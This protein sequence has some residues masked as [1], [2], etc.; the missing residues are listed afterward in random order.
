[1]DIIVFCMDFIRDSS[2]ILG[3]DLLLLTKEIQSIKNAQ[4]ASE[5]LNRVRVMIGSRKYNEMKCKFLENMNTD[6]GFIDTPV[7][8]NTKWLNN[9]VDYRYQDFVYLNLD[10]SDSDDG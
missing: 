8:L 10:D 2:S 9:I 6:V 1:M 3:G 7:D 4:H 5:W